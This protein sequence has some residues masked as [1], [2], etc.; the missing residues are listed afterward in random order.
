MCSKSLGLSATERQYCEL[1]ECDGELGVSRK[2]L[3]YRS[4]YNQRRAFPFS[5]FS[6]KE[7]KGSLYVSYARAF[8]RGRTGDYKVSKGPSD[9]SIKLACVEFKLTD[10]FLYQLKGSIAFTHVI[11]ASKLLPASVTEVKGFFECFRGFG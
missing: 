9:L 3:W 2:E 1:I 8:A 10:E 6:P 11:I 5:S 7:V 4:G